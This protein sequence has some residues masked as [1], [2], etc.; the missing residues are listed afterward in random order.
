MAESE[1]IT[2]RGLDEFRRELR[3]LDDQTFAAELKDTNYRV[4]H[5]VVVLASAKLSGY[6]R[7]E[8][9][10]AQTMR[11][12]RTLAAAKL[13]FGSAAVPFAVG[14]EFGAHHDVRR[15]TGRLGWNQFPQV[16]RGGRSIYPTIAAETSWIVR[17]YDASIGRIM[18]DAFPD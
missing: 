6:G 17:E 13:H 2:V 10:A 12:A 9:R 8:A 5:H 11:A 4:A 3:K 14:A 7:M 1:R 18:A 16:V 15:N